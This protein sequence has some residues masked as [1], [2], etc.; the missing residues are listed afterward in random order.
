MADAE[1]N[2]FQEAET[3]L[4]QR[5]AAIIPIYDV[6]NVFLAWKSSQLFENDE[7]RGKATLE[8]IV[9]LFVQVS[10]VDIEIGGT[11]VEACRQV[12]VKIGD[13]GTEEIGAAGFHL[14]AHHLADHAVELAVVDG[15]P[16]SV[17]RAG[18]KAAGEEVEIAAE[19]IGQYEEPDLIGVADVE[20]AFEAKRSR[21]LVYSGRRIEGN[22]V[23]V[24]FPVEIEGQHEPRIGDGVVLQRQIGQ[25][26]V[27]TEVGIAALVD[28]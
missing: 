20:D 24:G 22:I 27:A 16:E 1:E 4:P 19:M 15:C 10:I 12:V 18:V 26:G 7:M 25:G 6:D 2:S 8:F 13:M 23:P 17:F 5:P 9:V 11:C 21:R 3:Q 14:P 28:L